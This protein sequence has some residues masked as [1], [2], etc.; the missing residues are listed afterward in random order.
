MKK[1][2]LLSLSFAFFLT[3]SC[4]K[5]EKKTGVAPQENT[6][7]T[8]NVTQR[9]SLN[10]TEEVLLKQKEE[11]VNSVP[12]K[13][14]AV[15]KTIRKQEA[16]AEVV[17][18]RKRHEEFLANS[19]FKKS[20]QL[21]KKERKANGI[22]P[23]KYYEHEWE[24]NMSP[25]DG[26][27]HPENVF[28][29]IE[30][31]KRKRA[32]EFAQGRV[33]GD[34]SNN[35]WVERG[36]NNVGG[37]V[38]A[39]M[40][41]PNDATNETVF[42]GGVSGGLWKNTNIS[43]A[44]STWTRVNIPENLSVSSIDYDPNNKTTFYVGTGESYVD[45]DVNG[46]GLWKSTDGGNTFTRVFGGISGPTTFVSVANVTVN[47]PS[48]L[49]GN[50]ACY[51]NNSAVFGVTITSPITSNIVLIQDDAPPASD[52][53]GTITNASAIS[54]KIAL[55]RRGQCDF[56]VKVKAAQNAGAIA[57]II[58]NQ[59]EG[60][61][62]AMGGSDSSITIPTVMITK[63][64]G[65][66]LEA[67]LLQGSVNVTLNP[68]SAG[69]FT[70]DLVPGQQ[71]INDVRVRN[72]NGNSEIYVAAA[73]S[74]YKDAFTPNFLGSTSYGLFKST[75]GGST[76]TE[77]ELPLTAN[78]KKHCPNDIEIGA[79]G[80]IWL[81]TTNSFVYGNGGGKIFASTDG[82]SFTQKHAIT[83]GKRTQ[84]VAS[85]SNPDKLY[86]L[87][88]L[89]VT[90]EIESTI[91]KTTDGFTTTTTQ[92]LPVD[93]ESAERFTTFG[94]TGQ[95][96][97]FNLL[98]AIDPTNDETVYVGGI[99]L[100]KST[101]GCAAWSQIS[102]WYGGFGF[103]NVHSDHHG[104]A[105]GNG[106]SSKL[107]FGNDGGV[108]FSNDAGAVIAARN[109]G[110]NITQFYSVGVAPTGITG[111][112]LS[113]DHFAAG[114]QDNGTHYFNGVGSGVNGSTQSQ[115]GDG[116]FVMFD[117]GT[118]KYYISNYV[119]NNMINYRRIPTGIVRPIS[120]ES[121]SS[122][123]F[124]C[125][126]VLDSRL[127]LLYSDYS[128]REPSPVFQIARYKNIKSGTVERTFLTNALLTSAPTA[129]AV[130]PYTTTSTTLLVGTRFGKL[131]R[132]T[133]ANGNPIWND[134]TGPFF[135]GSI[136]DVEYGSSNN[137]IFVTM[138]NYNVVS[139]WYSKDAG[140]TWSNKEGNFP[141]IPVKAILAN[142]L[143]NV[144]GFATE[145]IIG[146][147]LGVWYSNNFDSENPTWNQAYNGMSN[148]KVTDLD[149]RNDNT[150][151]AATYGRG[152]FSG[153]F[154]AET[155]SLNENTISNKVNVYPNPS[156]GNFN[157]AIENYSGTLKIAV[158]DINGREIQSNVTEFSSEKA[159]N[160]QGLQTGVY[161]V[162][163]EGT[164]VSHS[165]KIVIN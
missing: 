109:S 142:P 157:I 158:Y 58:M 107:L 80:K 125:P 14:V 145:V 91:I 93:A 141:D 76:W 84:I 118:D 123:A 8:E 9:A 20:L 164:G 124:I 100:F 60:A 71:H 165:E 70:G 50:M 49:V 156:N 85:K 97:F 132:V 146:T 140:V 44:S 143:K 54:Q 57:V 126:M 37:R 18:L 33:P 4:S 111:G 40:F 17:A 81:A 131:L 73:D 94:F 6:V 52:G 62:V 43:N 119:F 41:D 2:I 147:E 68:N 74:Y 136:S 150:V 42:A 30:D 32:Q 7:A 21:S 75:N 134:I 151:F 87:G 34:A 65:D 51:P 15:S 16:T 148:V 160:L 36:P 5:S 113:G 128:V 46:D 61:P 31:L 23:K 39:V 55:I 138:H 86:V 79:D 72:N 116:G 89:G 108:Y 12:P 22:P 66:A 69:S 10:T 59:M 133:T 161:I 162:K 28:G 77:V 13:T 117:Q 149:L 155:L 25:V 102:H 137:E 101:N 152:I 26:K 64:D 144:G 120:S 92:P 110:L 95:Q 135:V 24:L 163:L 11:S 104:L 106:N 35:N 29:V 19:P 139:I 114:S 121:S 67:A 105:F 159:I 88:E 83:G 103:Q 154:T 78:G 112:G 3:L 1:R 127:D 122:G 45:G 98:I 129:F 82:I 27:T 53:C 96:A 99:D 47:S 38:R 90:N 115:G 56:V 63:T 153:T 48:S 130:S